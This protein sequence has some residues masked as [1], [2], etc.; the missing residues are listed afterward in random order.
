MYIT[1][2]QRFIGFDLAR[3]Y[4]IFGM[5]VVNFNTA[6]GSLNDNSFLGKFLNSFNGNSSTAFVI[7][8]GMGVALMTNRAQYTGQEKSKLK[9]IVIKR[10]GFL[11]AIGILLCLWWPADILHF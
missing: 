9:S 4:A 7:L 8:A 2:K 5:F 10:A 6:F 3:A 11:F 1:K